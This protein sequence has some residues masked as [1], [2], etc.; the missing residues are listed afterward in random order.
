MNSQPHPTTRRG[1]TMIEILTVVAIIAL[2]A[3]ITV[4]G[5]NAVGGNAKEKQTR[6]V[7]EV[8]RSTL[9]QAVPLDDAKANDKFYG[10]FLPTKYGTPATK[11]VSAGALATDTKTHDVIKYLSSNAGA[12]AAIQGLPTQLRK[13]VGDVTIPLDAWGNEIRFVFGKIR[14]VQGDSLV[15]DSTLGGLGGM[16]SKSAEQYWPGQS[17]YTPPASAGTMNPRPNNEL[18]LQAP[19]KGPF[20]VSAGP[21][22]N[23]ETHDDNLYSFEGN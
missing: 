17:S 19:D 15:T 22:G 10:N 11:S 6:T 23:F 2:L 1:F 7:L 21:D 5:M 13:T 4:V 14:V 3:T 12:K 20:W 18:A 9:A 16:Y 8:L